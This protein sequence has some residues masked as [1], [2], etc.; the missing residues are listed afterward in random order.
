MEGRRGERET[1]ECLLQVTESTLTLST[2]GI[3]VFN[4]WTT[5]FKQVSLYEKEELH[6]QAE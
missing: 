3:L 2:I 4:R 1:G 5:N 6:R